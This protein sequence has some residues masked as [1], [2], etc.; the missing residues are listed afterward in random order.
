MEICWRINRKELI[1]FHGQTCMYIRFLWNTVFLLEK[2]QFLKTMC[3]CVYI[4]T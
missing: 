2:Y 3:L 1:E 4:R